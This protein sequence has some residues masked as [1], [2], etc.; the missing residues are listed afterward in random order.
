MC[1]AIII[2]ALP[3][4]ILHHGKTA[5]SEEKCLTMASAEKRF[6][7][8]F[9]SRYYLADQHLCYCCT[10]KR[11]CLFSA[12]FSSSSLLGSLPIN[13]TCWKKTCFEKSISFNTNVLRRED[14]AK[15]STVFYLLDNSM[16]TVATDPCS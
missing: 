8:F 9:L 13:Y 1:F 15:F 4:A 2:L 3:I 7:F 16:R 5:G 11:L 6:F 12:D 10:K 14:S